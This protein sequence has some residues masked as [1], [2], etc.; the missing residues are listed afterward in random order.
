LPEY[1][2]ATVDP[3][4][5]ADGISHPAPSII[6]AGNQMFLVAEKKLICIVDRLTEAPLVLLAAYYA[7]NMSYPIGLNTF[8]TFL[9]YVVLDKKPKKMTACFSHFITHSSS[10]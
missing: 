4:A 3:N 10:L 9:E 6:L 5:V 7:Y 8:Y 1:S 2:Q